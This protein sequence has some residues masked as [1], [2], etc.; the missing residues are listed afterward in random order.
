MEKEK[1][2]HAEEI[3]SAR[4]FVHPPENN[5]A[6]VYSL[7]ILSVEIGET[8]EEYGTADLDNLVKNFLQ[9]NPEV[10]GR[11]NE[12][13]LDIVAHQS[14]TQHGKINWILIIGFGFAALGLGVAGYKIIRKYQKSP[15][16]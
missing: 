15:K 6:E 3:E 8:P 11:I 16:R 13:N 4:S 1:W 12:E 7:P 9:E 5:N 10:S 14:K 2:A